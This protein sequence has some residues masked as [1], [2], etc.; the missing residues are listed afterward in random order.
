MQSWQDT[1]NMQ[2]MR[3]TKQTSARQ[4]AVSLQKMWCSKR[5]LSATIS[6]VEAQ[7]AS[8]VGASP[9]MS[10]ECSGGSIYEHG[11]AR[12]TCKASGGAGLCKRAR[13]D[14]VT[15]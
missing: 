1:V 14:E 10:K 4:E 3:C 8:T 15:M 9:N 5:G 2:G 7:Y 12:Y 13:Q 6:L 11:R